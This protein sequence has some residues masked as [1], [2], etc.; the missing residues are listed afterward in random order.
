VRKILLLVLMVTL[1]STGIVY[2]KDG[3]NTP[4]KFDFYVFSLSWEPSFC[5]SKPNKKECLN[6]NETRYEASNL[7]LHGL[8]PSR[9]GDSR[10]SYEFCGKGQ[11][12]RK[13]DRGGK[14]CRM[15]KLD[16]SE[17]TAKNL[18]IYMPGYASCLERHEWYKH[19]TCSGLDENDYFVKAYSLV[20]I[21]PGANFAKY[22]SGHIGNTIRDDTLLKEF[23][24]DFGQGNGKLVNLYCIN[25]DGQTVLSEIRI[26]LKKSL[27]INNGLSELLIE[28][29]ASEHGSCP[30]EFL[31]DTV[32]QPV[33]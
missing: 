16:L 22:I 28:P 11:N 21:I 32:N 15:P 13:L 17:E 33:N 6:L 27:L 31:I 23:E 2:S 18:A 3:D 14:W 10:H 26:Y 19:G 12:F 9:I 5:H 30:H 7:V 25:V 20:A 29:D 24:K 1:V 8:W 4:G